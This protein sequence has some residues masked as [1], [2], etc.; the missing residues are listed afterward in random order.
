MEMESYRIEKFKLCERLT[1]VNVLNVNF[2]LAIWNV[3]SS[4]VF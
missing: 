4:I 1:L 2:Y 3:G